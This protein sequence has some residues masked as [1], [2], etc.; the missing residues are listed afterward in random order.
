MLVAGIFGFLA[1]LTAIVVVAAAIRR[2]QRETGVETS[3][4]SLKWNDVKGAFSSG[5]LREVRH[6]VALLSESKKLD[7]DLGVDEIFSLSEEG[8]GYVQP[9]DI[10]AMLGDRNS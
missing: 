4:R 2:H 1:L 3:W 6:D 5:S 10:I 7:S 8:S 9:R